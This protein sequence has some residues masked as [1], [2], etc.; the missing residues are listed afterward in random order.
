MF[1]IRRVP[2]SWHDHTSRSRFKDQMI[3]TYDWW[4]VDKVMISRKSLGD[5]HGVDD[6]IRKKSEQG[7]AQSYSNL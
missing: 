3:H 4:L 7:H 5:G 1:G 6:N 2:W